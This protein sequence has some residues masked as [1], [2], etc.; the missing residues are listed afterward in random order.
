MTDKILF[1]SSATKITTPYRLNRS[2]NSLIAFPI[3][4]P[5]DVRLNFLY[6]PVC[7]DHTQLFA[8]I[9]PKDDLFT[10]IIYLQAE[11]FFEDLN[12]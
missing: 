3:I 5:D 8:T 7:I 12:N 6:Q 4:V 11:G 2:F 9:A 10:L 1:Y